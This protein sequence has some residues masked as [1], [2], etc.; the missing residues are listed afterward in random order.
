ML[1]RDRFVPLQL[2]YY[3]TIPIYV[4]RGR[5]FALKKS[6][7]VVPI[8]VVVAV[9]ALIM[10]NQEEY[11]EVSIINKILITIGASMLSAV[12]GYFLLKSDVNNV[13]P[14][15]TNNTLNK[16]KRNGK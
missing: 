1:F 7:L 10:L 6:K 16:K 13:D 2:C 5:K 14:K 8:M 9:L 12:V 15:S 4:C 11:D 3:G